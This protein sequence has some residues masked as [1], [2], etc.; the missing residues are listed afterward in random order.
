MTDWANLDIGSDS[1]SDD[2][3][4]DNVAGGWDDGDDVVDNWEEAQDPEEKA[5]QKR[6]EQERIEREKQEAIEAEK[7]R[8]QE[9]KEER[10]RRKQEKKFLFD[11]AYEDE[12]GLFDVE[13]TN[14]TKERMDFQNALDAL[15]DLGQNTDD[16]T[17]IDI[18]R[19]V[20]KTVTDFKAYEQAIEMKISKIFPAFNRDSYK[21]KK[22]FDTAKNAQDTEKVKIIEC[23]ITAL[24]D[25][26][27]SVFMSQLQKHLNEIYNKKINVK[28][29][30]TNQKGRSKIQIA[31]KGFNDVSDDD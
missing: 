1:E 28:V 2:N 22:E 19:Y 7:R 29:G 15:G 20:P 30:K 12:G 23:L 17:K 3:Q 18:G 6:E 8:K 16:P 11:D 25:S 4:E 26:Y 13:V 24:A 31:D 9:L 10:E 27:K 5:R 21:T 14:E